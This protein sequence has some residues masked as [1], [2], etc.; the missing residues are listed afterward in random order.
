MVSTA[1]RL[2][3]SSLSI[4]S[5]IASLIWSAILSGCPSVTDSE[6]NRRRGTVLLGCAAV[7]GVAGPVLS[8]SLSGEAGRDG[9][10]HR[11]RDGVLAG[12][13]NLHRATL[14][15]EDHHRVVR[16]V[17]GAARPDLVHHE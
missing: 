3:G 13:R 16:G 7:A 12:Q 14:R 10:P 2:V 5:R 6:V 15:V 8:G 11:V 9:V 1:T 4:A 17:E